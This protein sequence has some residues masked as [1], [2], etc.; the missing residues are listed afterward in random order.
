MS[1]SNWTGRSYTR[2]PRRPAC[3]GRSKMSKDELVEAVGNGA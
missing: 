2:A 1:W 3:P